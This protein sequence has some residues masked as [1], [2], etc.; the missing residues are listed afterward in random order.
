MKT[1]TNDKII[2]KTKLTIPINFIIAVGNIILSVLAGS[3]FIFLNALYSLGILLAK[4]ITINPSIISKVFKIRNVDEYK[5]YFIYKTVG[6]ILLVSSICYVF[7]S[8]SLLNGG[9]NMRYT[10]I[11]G[12]AIA[13]FT[14]VQLI[15]SIIGCVSAMKS[16]DLIFKSIKYTNLAASLI[17]VVFMQ[18][19]IMS[20]SFMG[21]INK[22]YVSNG[23]SGIFFGSMASLVGLYMLLYTIVL[24]KRRKQNN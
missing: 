13:L 4:S 15:I 10:A 8:V 19:A 23:V 21:D 6:I 14:F 22:L 17:S 3:F 12:I 1:L 9:S 7:Y 11:I 16:Q 24:K 5:E 2:R 20:F 18:A